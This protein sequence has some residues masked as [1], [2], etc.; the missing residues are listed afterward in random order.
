MEMLAS[1]GC[2]AWSSGSYW[3]YGA[4]S[5]PSSQDA[6]QG[7]I[8]ESLSITEGTGFWVAGHPNSAQSA[9]LDMVGSAQL[10]KP[11]QVSRHD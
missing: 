7:A 10:R 11:G 5:L 2:G 3:E 4:C 9:P 1:G 8:C 6:G